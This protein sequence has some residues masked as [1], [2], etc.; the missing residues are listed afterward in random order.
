MSSNTPFYSTRSQ[1]LREMRRYWHLQWQ[2]IVFGVIPVLFGFYLFHR[3]GASKVYDVHAPYLFSALIM[4][5]VT[6]LACK[7]ERSPQTVSYFFGLPRDRAVAWRGRLAFLLLVSA[8]YEVLILAGTWFKL[9]GAGI[10]PHYRL[11]PEQVMLPFLAVAFTLWCFHDPNIVTRIAT[12]STIL[13]CTVIWFCV[14]YGNRIA[15]VES[16]HFH[17]PRA[18]SLITQC[19]AAL[20]MLGLTV[21][22]FFGA[23]N[24]WMARER[25]C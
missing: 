5:Y 12:M 11:H 2:S 16:N 14:M 10:T 13:L 17:P 9:G 1:M 15:P 4:I 6:A 21:G 18:F 7:P 22:L 24:R 23:R 3:Y 25:T 8:G 19:I 20:L